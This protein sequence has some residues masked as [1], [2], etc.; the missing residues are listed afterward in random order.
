M[1]LGPYD[2]LDVAGED[3]QSMV[4]T[5]DMLRANG[6]RAIIDYA[7]ED[8]V[9]PG[10]DS[11]KQQ[12]SATPPSGNEAGDGKPSSTASTTEGAGATSAF[13]STYGVGHALGGMS[14][15]GLRAWLCFCLNGACCRGLGGRGWQMGV[16]LHLT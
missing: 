6:I 15:R 9:E 4:P 2:F 10:N 12:Q 7:A 16:L 8:D 3:E 11:S 13:R 1:Q 5:M 14:V